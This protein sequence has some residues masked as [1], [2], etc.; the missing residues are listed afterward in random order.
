MLR[1]AGGRLIDES[2]A[3]SD[4]LYPV[5]MVGHLMDVY[6]TTKSALDV[7]EIKEKMLLAFADYVKRD[8]AKWTRVIKTI[9]FRSDTSR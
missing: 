1:D 8:A 2:Y 6:P 9:G 7:P 3:N 5:A 4:R